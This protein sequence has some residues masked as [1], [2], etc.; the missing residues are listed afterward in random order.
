MNIQSEIDYVRREI[1]QAQWLMV[2]G[3]MAL[4]TFAVALAIVGSLYRGGGFLFCSAACCMS[5]VGFAWWQN[6]LIQ[7]AGAYIRETQKATETPILWEAWLEI[8]RQDRSLTA[9]LALFWLG[10]LCVF[11]YSVGRGLER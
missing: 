7:R 2:L 4:F 8:W 9:P 10:P 5:M 11:L 6:M 1:R 3:L